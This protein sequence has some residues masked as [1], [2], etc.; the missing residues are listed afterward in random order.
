VVDGGGYA[1][2]T[3]DAG[4]IA[5]LATPGPIEES[6]LVPT[7]LT[8]FEFLAQGCAGLL[9]RA[10]SPVLRNE[11]VELIGGA[12]QRDVDTVAAAPAFPIGNTE[13][14]VA[15]EGADVS[16]GTQ[17]MTLGDASG[18]VEVASAERVDLVGSDVA[19][20]VLVLVVT[21]NPTGAATSSSAT[22]GVHGA[23]SPRRSTGFTV[24]QATSHGPTVQAR[25]RE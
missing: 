22:P 6:V 14:L 12:R 1:D 7:S 13:W 23:R 9:A 2:A 3:T 19:E 11:R 24:N 25:H 16:E 4:F 21:E 15:L 20:L 17:S 18:S 5:V 10:A 8:R